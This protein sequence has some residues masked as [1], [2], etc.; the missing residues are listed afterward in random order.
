MPLKRDQPQTESSEVPDSIHEDQ[1]IGIME[2]V[3]LGIRF[4]CLPDSVEDE[5]KITRAGD[6]G[7]QAH[8]LQQFE[9]GV[10]YLVPSEQNPVRKESPPG[11][12]FD[13]GLS[14]PRVIVLAEKPRFRMAQNEQFAGI[15]FEHRRDPLEQR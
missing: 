9:F 11:V 7:E 2:R 8:L 1:T 4:G 14:F 10:R 13:L 12:L 5:K 15:Q 6:V 3:R